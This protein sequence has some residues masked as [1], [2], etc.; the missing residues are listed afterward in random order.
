MLLAY[1]H[2][3]ILWNNINNSLIL[4]KSLLI[5]KCFNFNYFM[6]FFIIRIKDY[7]HSRLEH[8]LWNII[9]YL[10]KDNVWHRWNNLLRHGI[11]SVL[12]GN[13]F[14][15]FTIFLNCWWLSFLLSDDSYYQYFFV[16]TY[17]YLTDLIDA[18]VTIIL[19]LA[20]TYA[21]LLLSFGLGPPLK[22]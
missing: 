4:Y 22:V 19:I 8:I 14:F 10:V 16:V 6:T 15:N 5:Y 12:T 3:V 2:Q 7:I 21:A 17:V 9:E 20:C 11:F 1:I 13:L 18:R